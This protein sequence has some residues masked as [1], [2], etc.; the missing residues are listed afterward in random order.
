[1][2][3][4]GNS[5]V[6]SIHPV[7]NLLVDRGLPVAGE[8]SLRIEHCLLGHPGARLQ[9]IRRVLSHPQALAQCRDYL[10]G[11]AD[12]RQEEAYDTAGAVK[13][14]RKRGI[15]AEAAIASAQAALDYGMDVLAERVQTHHDNFT[16]FLVLSHHPR[17][18]EKKPLKTSLVLILADGPRTLPAVLD[19][20]S[21]RNVDLLMFDAHKRQGYPWEYLYYV[22]FKGSPDDPCQ[23]EA[24][25]E[26]AEQV[27]TLHLIGPYPSGR[28]CEARL[29]RRPQKPS[30]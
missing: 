27:A 1:M 11:L 4:A 3:P 15:K 7:W 8:I 5:L 25:Q 2:A 21:R 20:L 6:G 30:H 17:H 9:D 23:K 29:H 13:I 16:R 28:T 18:F 26:I 24:V 19:S 22:E 14:I 12:V 10:S